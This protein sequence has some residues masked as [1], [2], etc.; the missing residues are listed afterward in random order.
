VGVGL[1]L[2]GLV[3]QQSRS[4]QEQ[5]ARGGEADPLR[6]Q[7]VDQLSVQRPL[8]LREGGR[9]GGGGGVQLLG[10]PDDRPR[11]SDGCEDGDLVERERWGSVDLGH[12]ATLSPGPARR[13]ATGGASVQ[14]GDAL[15]GLVQ[16]R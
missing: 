9:H 8:Q 1:E 14:A 10:G 13:A 12:P 4:G 3:E 11:V 16:Q 15:A 6:P 5:L 7:P 2:G